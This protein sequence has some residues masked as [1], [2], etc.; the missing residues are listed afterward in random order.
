MRPSDRLAEM[1][2]TCGAL[3]F[4]ALLCAGPVSVAFAQLSVHAGD[5]RAAPGTTA[6]VPISIA[7]PAGTPAATLQFNL[8]VVAN[9]GAPA[10][11]SDVKFR[12]V[13]G[14]PTLSL[15]HGPGTVLVGW[16]SSLSPVLTGTMQIGTLSVPIPAGATSGQTYTVQVIRPS[17]T[18]DG[19]ADLGKIASANG[20]IRVGAK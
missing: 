8:T 15:N 11:A 17:G 9:G 14:P 12:S 5:V 1:R 7:L 19:S 10:I 3:I 18:S 4:G 20:T 6:T 16:L 13:V 2:Y